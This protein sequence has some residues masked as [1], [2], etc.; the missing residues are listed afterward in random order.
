MELE[1]PGLRPDPTLSQDEQITRQRRVAERATFSPVDAPAAEQLSEHIVV[2]VDQAFTDEAALSAAVAV[3]NGS[4][5]E[6]ST[7][8]ASLRM[9][10]IPGL[11]AFREGEAV[12][13]ALADLDVDPAVLLCD[14]SG[15]IHYRQ[16][17]LATHIGVVFDIPAIGVA[18]S[19]LCGTPETPIAEP[20]SK[21]DQVSIAADDDV[22]PVTTDDTD[23]PTI[24]VAF[25]SRQ[26]ERTESQFIN[27]LYVSPGHRVDVGRAV[28]LVASSCEEYKLPDPIRLA[29][30]AA[31]TTKEKD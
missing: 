12:I 21:G 20:L 6:T 5:I 10:Y 7:A 22:E 13:A 9:P 27:P 15:R 25:Q 1:N 31:D 30:K 3:S 29:D 26:F 14:G 4:I 17:G 24:G 28:S 18:K 23:W 11:L 8:R 2:G 16:A 19:L